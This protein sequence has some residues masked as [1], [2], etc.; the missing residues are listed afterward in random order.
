MNATSAREWLFHSQISDADCRVSLR[1]NLYSTRPFN[2]SLHR[3]IKGIIILGCFESAAVV[4]HMC[5]IGLR[6]LDLTITGTGG[7][8]VEEGAGAEDASCSSRISL[9]TSAPSF[10]HIQ[11]TNQSRE[12]TAKS[13]SSSLA[14][15]RSIT[16]LVL[17]K[18][19]TVYLT[20]GSVK[21]ILGG[22]ADG[23]MKWKELVCIFQYL[24]SQY[25]CFS[26]LFVSL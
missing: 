9:P 4:L 7:K 10:S 3:H 15:L 20:Q 21:A 1:D 23:I 12:A 26:F 13:L 14:N 2:T 6:T 18:A 11:P 22:V 19:Q 24:T 8:G 16:H 5:A 25:L 17:R